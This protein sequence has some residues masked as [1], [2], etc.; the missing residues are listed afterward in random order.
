[1]TIARG[2]RVPPPT[3]AAH[4]SELRARGVHNIRWKSGR[5]SPSM[6][7]LGKERGEY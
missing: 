2:V 5:L 7:L 6:G 4:E 1:M 3:L